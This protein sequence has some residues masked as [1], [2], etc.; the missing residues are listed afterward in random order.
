MDYRDLRRE[1]LR[2]AQAAEDRHGDHA[3]FFIEVDGKEYRATKISHGARGQ[4]SAPLE[5]FIARQLRLT[6][7]QLR[8][9]VE[10]PLTGE[11]FLENWRRSS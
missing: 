9:F 5:A 6:V 8:D 2:K 7:S 4:I 10:C 11:A 1:L 3:F